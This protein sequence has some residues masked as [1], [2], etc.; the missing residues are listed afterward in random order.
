MR[1]ATGRA[2]APTRSQHTYI[3]RYEVRAKDSSAAK[4]I[5]DMVDYIKEHHKGHSGIIY[6]LSKRDTEV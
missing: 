3:Y 4:V 1:R 6:C 2:R 5:D